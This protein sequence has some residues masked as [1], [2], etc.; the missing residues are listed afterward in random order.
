MGAWGGGLE[1]T[2]PSKSTATCDNR[3]GLQSV[4]AHD[5]R[6]GGSR[7]RAK[8]S[9]VRK[10]GLNSTRRRVSVLHLGRAILPSCAPRLLA[11]GS[12]MG[13]STDKLT[14][15]KMTK[16]CRKYQG[17]QYRWVLLVLG[18]TYW[19][20]S[21]PVYGPLATERGEKKPQ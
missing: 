5:Y 16:P 4:T 19:S 14:S 20:A 6:E 13:G 11:L 12:P 1:S 18:D 3:G 9:L 15:S 21:R 7:W 2:A 17:L 8:A 10:K